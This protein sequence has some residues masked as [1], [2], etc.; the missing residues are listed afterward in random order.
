ME[1]CIMKVDLIY[2]KQSKSFVRIRQSYTFVEAST[3]TEQNT[4]YWYH[5]LLVLLDP[6]HLLLTIINLIHLAFIEI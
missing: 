5:I 6:K 1:L 4:S 3:C 2:T